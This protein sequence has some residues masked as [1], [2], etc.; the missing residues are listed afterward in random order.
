LSRKNLGHTSIKT[1]EIYLHT[2]LEERKRIYQE[3]F[4]LVGDVRIRTPATILALQRT[5]EDPSTP[6]PVRRDPA[7]L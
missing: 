4:P 6:P 5:G 3:Y 7:A 2:D 1:T